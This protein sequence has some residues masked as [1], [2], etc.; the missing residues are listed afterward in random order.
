LGCCPYDLSNVS[1]ASPR[2][3]LGGP[4]WPAF[5]GA[6]GDVAG[7]DDA[8]SLGD[9]CVEIARKKGEGQV[10]EWRR[11]V[12]SNGCVL[13]SFRGIFFGQRTTVV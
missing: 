5:L 8:E 2:A 3:N 4:T 1:T 11:D 13:I 12:R 6:A 9:V 10:S 7:D